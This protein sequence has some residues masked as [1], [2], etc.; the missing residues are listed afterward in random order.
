MQMLDATNAFQLALPAKLANLVMVLSSVKTSKVWLL[1]ILWTLTHSAWVVG[2]RNKV[3]S[4]LTIQLEGHCGDPA[5][6]IL[7]GIQPC[8]GSP[9]SEVWKEYSVVDI[10]LTGLPGW[11][12]I[13]LLHF[14]NWVDKS[15]SRQCGGRATYRLIASGKCLQESQ[16]WGK[17]S[18]VG[19]C[20]C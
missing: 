10:S 1:W 16:Q 14:E 9:S 19:M 12:V 6:Y 13:F 5:V 8:K 11:G 3:N 4:L 2:F 7:R 15:S 20:L 18:W 17:E